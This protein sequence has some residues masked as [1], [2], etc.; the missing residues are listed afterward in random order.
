MTSEESCRV[1]LGQI[2]N[3]VTDFCEPEETTLQGVAKL[4]ALYHDAKAIAAWGYVERLKE[5]AKDE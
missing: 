3:I 5:E 4:L 2:A 1:M